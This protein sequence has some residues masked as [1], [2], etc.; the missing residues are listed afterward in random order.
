MMR[1]ARGSVSAVRA[2]VVWT[3]LLSA[4]GGGGQQMVA[5]AEETFTTGTKLA[6]DGRI[7]KVTDFQGI[8]AVKPV[9]AERFTPVCEPMVLKPG[10]WLRTD[11]RGA[12]AV[13]ARM[14]GDVRIT[15]G[16]G[17]VLELADARTF[18]LAAGE[19]QLAAEGETPVT[20]TGPD[21][22]P[23]AVKGTAVYRVQADK[24]VRVE[25]KPRWLEGFEGTVADESIGSLVVNVDGRNMPLTVG[26]HKV[27]VD[28]RDQIAR[29]TI[30]ESFVNHTNGRLEGVFYFPLPQD[31]SISGFGMWIGNELVEADVVEKQ[32]AREIYETILRERRDPGLLEWSG[33]NLFKA[34]VF[35]IEARSE[36]RVKITYTQVLP[37]RGGAYR[38]GYALESEL[39]KQHPLREL[40]IDVRIH[41]VLPLA[42]VRCPTHLARI[43]RTEHSARVEFTAQEYTPAS[44]F[45]VVV[46]VDAG[47]SEAVMIPHR[48]GEDGYFM[49]M[50]LPPGEQG[51]WRRDVLP[52]GEPLELLILADTS[53]SLD[54]ASRRAQAELVAALLGSL[55]PRDRFNLAGFDVACDW[56]FD[57]PVPADEKNRAAASEFLDSRV[58]LGWTDLDRAID[59]ALKQCGPKTHVVY[60]GDGIPVTAAT[61]PVAAAGRL[62][63]L[64]EASGG[65]ATF[66]AVSVG[67]RFESVVLKAIASLGGA[68]LGG[69][70]M[71]QV[72]GGQNPAQVA[73]ELLGE[74]IEPAIRNMKIEF[75]GLRTARV[76]PGEL[77][78]LA[79]GTQQI[80]LGRYLPEGKDQEGE[81][82]VTGEVQGRPVRFRTAVKLADAEAGNSFIPRLWARMHLDS[83]LEQGPS[84]SIQDEIIALSEEYHVITPYT[85]LLVLETDADRE[86]FGVK[87]RFQMRDGEKFFAEG[88]DAANYELVQQQMRR[89]GN[90]RL[91]L[92]RAVLMEL[93]EL[94]RYPELVAMAGPQPSFRSGPMS[95]RDYSGMGPMS[96]MGGMGGGI[97]G[98]FFGARGDFGTVGSK[99]L[100]AVA[101]DSVSEAL[102]FDGNAFDGDMKG[103]P[104]ARDYV[105]EPESEELLEAAA[106]EAMPMTAAPLGAPAP[107]EPMDADSGWYEGNERL[108]AR[109]PQ[110]MAGPADHFAR[111]SESRRRSQFARGNRGW[112]A[113]SSIVSGFSPTNEGR[114]LRG[115]AYYG[116]PRQYT[117]WLGTLFPSLPAAPVD[118]PE[119]KPHPWPV[120]ARELA[121]SLLR[122]GALQ[123]IDGGL[124][125]KRR[126][127]SFDARTAELAGVS[128]TLSRVSPAGW[129]IRSGG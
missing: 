63:R 113:K 120:E 11:L 118:G 129:V 56:A 67:S 28:I 71:R 64:Y 3:V 29:T 19:L 17:T 27:S 24:L 43:G 109:K 55:G 93:A 102:A 127:E 114:I 73:R 119:E 14:A 8:V 21:K 117:G 39:L 108:L 128:E 70:S 68:S 45:E 44:D 23:V 97:G 47:Q 66:H 88:R 37:L 91:G 48:R 49:L 30:E 2:M 111:A 82:V 99:K 121:Q 69:G 105:A 125:V 98:G 59:S 7:G 80:L 16:P 18:N 6:D 115:E 84:Q 42:D 123:A 86:R 122:L 13:A 15:L 10:D 57:G 53:A 38:Y 41:S 12:N 94:G 92:R 4:I 35:P 40:A 83:L 100:R 5:A 22:T 110:S 96:G 95:G 58:S 76:Y 126:S 87:R 81:V 106:D 116:D 20:L 33:G 32:R 31:A 104:F 46:Q 85:S 65:G 103:D 51:A 50:L 79:P 36:K 77:P 61:D 26:Y 107:S 62:R 112:A 54:A 52:D 9:G 124:T 90:W 74:M 101:M 72:A 25:K 89:A 34:R 1:S 78:N 75:H 60:I